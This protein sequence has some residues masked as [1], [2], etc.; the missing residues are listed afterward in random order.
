MFESSTLYGRELVASEV[1]ILQ[2]LFVANPEYFLAVNGRLPGSNEAQTEF[3]EMPPPHL[4]FTKRWFA[5]LFDRSHELA[6]VAIIVSDLGA[7]EVWHI[8]LFLLATHLHGSGAASDI[9][10]ALEAWMLRSGAKWLRLGVVEGNLRAAR[11]WSSHGFR[12]VRI[13]LGV[14]TG[15]R[16]NDVHVLIKPLG[17]SGLAEYLERMPRDHPESQLP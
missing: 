4:A 15:G 7:S 16:I 9:Y 12:E 2:A 17:G 11:F 13:R 6:G 14:D 8:G 5:G 10:V 1:P 3:E